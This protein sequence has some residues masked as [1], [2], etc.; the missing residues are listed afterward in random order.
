M[1]LPENPFTVLS[2]VSG[3]ALLT[4]ATA[5]MLLSTSNRFAR[6][7]DRS[8]FLADYLERGEG[9]RPKTATAQELVMAEDRVA[10]IARALS[11]FYFAT[12]VF[13][14]ATMISIGGIVAGE[15]IGGVGFDVV[16]AIGLACGIAGFTALVSGSFSLLLESRLAARSLEME[17][18]EAKSAIGRA[19]KE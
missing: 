5:L 2:Y 3:P 13:A 14:M 16:I 17:A 19:L 7:I 12:A 15:Y 1:A 10:L 18:K 4:N 6:A 11:R 8:R 9:P